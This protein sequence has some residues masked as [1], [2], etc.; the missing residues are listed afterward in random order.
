MEEPKPA[1]I[2]R[3]G[4]RKRLHDLFMEQRDRLDE[5]FRK[6]FFVPTENEW[7]RYRNYEIEDLLGK[8]FGGKWVV[9]EHCPFNGKYCN[10]GLLQGEW[11]I[12]EC[13]SKH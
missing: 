9:N 1:M 13:R 2:S 8:W 12:N 4:A 6:L 3:D 10:W 11:A 5:R 7:G